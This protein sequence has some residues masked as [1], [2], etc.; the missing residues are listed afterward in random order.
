MHVQRA[1]VVQG[2]LFQFGDKGVRHRVRGPEAL[3]G[4]GGD[5]DAE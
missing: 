1:Q 5:M 2:T 4:K 3:P